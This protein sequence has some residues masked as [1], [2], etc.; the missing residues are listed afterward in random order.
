MFVDPLDPF[1][2]TPK[3][4]CIGCILIF[5][6]PL[7]QKTARDSAF[8]SLLTVSILSDTFVPSCSRFQSVYE[9]TS[10]DLTTDSAEIGASLGVKNLNILPPEELGTVFRGRPCFLAHFHLFNRNFSQ[11]SFSQ[12]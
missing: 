10:R 11:L 3:P 9:M 2:Q 5:V 4:S 7:T 6:P 1:R 8:A 12:K